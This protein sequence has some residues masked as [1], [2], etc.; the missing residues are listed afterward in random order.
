[1][2]RCKATIERHSTQMEQLVLLGLREYFMRVGG[3]NSFEIIKTIIYAYQLSWVEAE[4]VL[5]LYF[6]NHGNTNKFVKIYTERGIH[7]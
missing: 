6:L 4:R 2:I 5:F 3:Y 1:M 7:N